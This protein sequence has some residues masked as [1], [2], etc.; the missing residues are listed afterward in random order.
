MC[1]VNN[2]R[3]ELT[4]Y[5]TFTKGPEVARE[6]NKSKIV[7]P[8]FY[9]TGYE[10]SVTLS[11]Y[12]SKDTHAK[13]REQPKLKI[14][15]G[16]A[17]Q[18]ICKF[19]LRNDLNRERI[20]R[21]LKW[22]KRKDPSSYISVFNKLCKYRQISLPYSRL[23]LLSTRGETSELPLQEKSPHWTTRLHCQNQY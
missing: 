15:N 2:T 9:R 17:F 6:L 11:A 19:I 12:T 20:E 23:M 18:A 4:R 7:P 10:T 14:S 8:F 5:S 16:N 13:H 1:L 22:N 3:P 21:Q